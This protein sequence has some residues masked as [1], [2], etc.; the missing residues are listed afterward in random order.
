M[1]YRLRD[2]TEIDT[3]RDLSFDERNFLQKMLIYQHLG[4]GLEAFR[5]R[6]RHEG[7][8]VWSGPGTLADPGP[9]ARILLDMEQTIA[10]LEGRH[11]AGPSGRQ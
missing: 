3:A 6:W 8:P 5:A 10:E 1:L 11:L 4:E 7:N 9:A 2:G